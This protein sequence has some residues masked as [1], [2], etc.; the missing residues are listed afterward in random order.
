MFVK[1]EV[2]H[3]VLRE[4]RV[5]RDYVFA[6]DRPGKFPVVIF[7]VPAPR[8]ERTV[9]YRLGEPVPEKAASSI[10]PL[11]VLPT[12]VLLLWEVCYPT[13]RFVFHKSEDAKVVVGECDAQSVRKKVSPEG[14]EGEN[15][16]KP[17]DDDSNNT[18]FRNS[19]KSDREKYGGREGKQEA[20][21]RKWETERFCKEGNMIL[22]YRSELAKDRRITRKK[23]KSSE[24]REDK[25]K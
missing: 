23:Q 5:K 18:G 15:H 12:P 9:E 25:P 3:V 7:V 10:S 19:S 6:I 11:I 20:K 16:D 17:N 4:H 1:E 24:K 14:R 8:I 22:E 13:Q 21:F 2:A